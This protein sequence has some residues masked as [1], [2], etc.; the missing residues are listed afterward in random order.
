MAWTER[1]DVDGKLQILGST[2]NSA[3]YLTR[4][5]KCERAQTASISLGSDDSIKVWLDGAEVFAKDVGR[6]VAADQDQATLE[7][8]AGESQL[9]L[10]IVNGGGPT[11]Y[12]FKMGGEDL[13][14]PLVA[15][16]KS[17]P[18]ALDDA[19]RATST[20][21]PHPALTPASTRHHPT[22]TP[23]TPRRCPRR[24][25]PTTPSCRSAR[26]P[27]TVRGCTRTSSGCSSPGCG[28]RRPRTTCC[29][30]TT[31]A[32]PRPRRRAPCYPP[33]LP[34]G[35]LRATPLTTAPLTTHDAGEASPYPTH[36]S[37][38]THYSPIRR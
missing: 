2:G 30:R 17:E 11:G 4:R 29:S 26:A 27:P 25:R 5:I 24:C 23:P 7:L 15:A 34:S 31:R 6:G 20:L 36:H 13:P 16:L 12:Y 28:P 32:A 38:L 22:L 37:P 8:P 19:A 14:G 33:L 3:I 35:G 18:D 10:K 1:E 9:L 21:A